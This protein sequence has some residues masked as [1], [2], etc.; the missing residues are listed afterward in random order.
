MSDNDNYLKIL[1]KIGDIA[2]DVA[3][4]KSELSHIKEASEKHADNLEN[5]TKQD[6]VLQQEMLDKIGSVRDDVEAIKKEDIRMNELMDIHIKG[7][8]QNSERLNIEK[9]AREQQFQS[10]KTENDKQNLEIKQLTKRVELA[11]FLPKF[12]SNLAIILKWVGGIAV[13]IMAIVK[14]LSLL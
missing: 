11:E 8:N 13:A 6:T 2:T 7:V 10:L 14:L 4:V 12:G 1:E 5:H 3:V 9:E